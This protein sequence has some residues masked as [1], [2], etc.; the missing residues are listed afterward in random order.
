MPISF[1]MS[2]ESPS[3]VEHVHSTFSDEKYWLARLAAFGGDTTLDSFFVDADGTVSVTTTQDLRHDA[4]PAIVAKLYRGDLNILRNETWEPI[5]G[6]R[7]SGEISVDAVGA[8]G[9]GRGAALLGP[10]RTGSRLKLTATEE[11]R[12]PLIGG[13]IERYIAGQFASGISEV[14][15][16]TTMWI[17]EHRLRAADWHRRYP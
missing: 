7:V 4:L 16:F 11:F 10:L 13:R 15:R 6:R 8:P 3:S 17:A 9:S 14:Q 1:D 12:V 2:F 5:G